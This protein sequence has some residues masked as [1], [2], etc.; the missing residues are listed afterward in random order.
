MQLDSIDNGKAFDFG[1]VSDAY[2][3]YRD[4]YPKSM[5]DKLTAFGIGKNGQQILDLGSG[6]AILPMNLYHTGAVFTATDI[7]DNQI[8]FGQQLARQKGMSIRFRVCPAE[9]TGFDDSQFDVVTAVQCFHYFD[10]E[11]AAREIHRIL[12]PHGLF[13]KI[14]MDWLPYEDK[15][16]ME[17]EQLVLQYNPQWS[18]GGFR[19][20]A[21]TFPQWAENRFAISTIHSYDTLLS[22][23]KEQWIGRIK[24]CRGIGASLSPE[25]TAA[26]ENEYRHLLANDTEPLQL[27]H[28]IHIEIYRSV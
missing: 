20:F 7:S 10:S 28:Q 16:I 19:Q 1:N 2:A 5:Y 26:F 18:G 21:Y 4:I 22:F 9:N 23:T 8:R 11:K 25:K 17:M 6:T 13:C 12:K 27:L 14:F 24:S 3:Q 15:K